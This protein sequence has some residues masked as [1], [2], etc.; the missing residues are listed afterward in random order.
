MYAFITSFFM[1][2][3]KTEAF[4]NKIEVYIYLYLLVHAKCF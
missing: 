3:Y 1:F 4:F 2:I